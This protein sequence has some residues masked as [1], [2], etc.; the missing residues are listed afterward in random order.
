MVDT[1]RYFNYFITKA[2]LS[3]YNSNPTVV[4]SFSYHL[5]QYTPSVYAEVTLVVNEDYFEDFKNIERLPIRDRIVE[6]WF[7][8]ELYSLKHS[9]KFFSGPFKFCVVNYEVTNFGVT[10]LDIEYS[11]INSGKLVVLKCVDPVFYAMQ[12]DE[13]HESYSSTTISEV[14]SK[15]VSRNGG[16]VGRIEPTDYSYNWLQAQLTDYEMIRS[17]LPYARSV[18]GDLLYSFFM[19]NEEAYF[20]PIT[21][22]IK[23][24]YSVKLDM[25]KNSR[26]LVYSTNFKSLI[27]RYGSRDRLFH[28]NRGYDNFKSFT[29]DPMSRQSYLSSSSSERKQ[30]KGFA[31]QYVTGSIDEEELQ[32]IY[33][34]NL[35]HRVYTFGR[36]VDTAAEVIPELTPLSCLEVLSQEDGKTKD[37][38]GLYYVASVTYN[39]GMTNV[40]PYQP[41]VYMVLCSELDSEGME[42]SEGG[43]IE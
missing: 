18:G 16:R 35:R 39:Y 5:S 9:E 21:Q 27:E 36:V 37:L 2:N 42:S 13:K 25:I 38:D 15:I 40:Y 26:E 17:M 41:F 4:K 28:F 7:E 22:S 23:T 32:R 24:P 10:E 33:I 1:L 29:P 11:D 30:H 12:L 19:F 31:S 6:V 20:A 43:P 34:S 3:W 8:D 14:V